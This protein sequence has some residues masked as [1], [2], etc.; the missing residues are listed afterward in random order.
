MSSGG[1]EGRE[2]SFHLAH[3]GSSGASPH[4]SPVSLPSTLAM[5][6]SVWSTLPIHS[7]PEATVCLKRCQI[8]HLTP[9]TAWHGYAT[10]P[11]LEQQ[12]STATA[13]PVSPLYQPFPAAL[14]VPTAVSSIFCMWP[15]C[16]T[17]HSPPCCMGLAS[18]SPGGWY[19]PGIVHQADFCPW[20]Y[21]RHG[22]TKPWKP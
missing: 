21:A 20:K 3:F 15:F 8:P 11:P 1:A 22:W 4:L 14:P 17:T 10:Y 12:P 2:G 6:I 9:W 16:S 19:N 7:L 13:P 5:H 18:P